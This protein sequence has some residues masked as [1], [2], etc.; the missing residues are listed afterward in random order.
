MYSNCNI[1]SLFLTVERLLHVMSF[2]FFKDGQAFA[3]LG[4]FDFLVHL[5][6]LS[7][8]CWSKP[9]KLLCSLHIEKLRFKPF[10][11]E[12]IV[13][14]TVQPYNLAAHLSLTLQRR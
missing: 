1:H 11:S 12:I 3:S 5:T 13:L 9:C 6:C 8:D 10:C 7:L 2:L 14:T 4:N